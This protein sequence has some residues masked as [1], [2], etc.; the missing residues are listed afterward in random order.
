MSYSPEWISRYMEARFFEFDPVLQG[1]SASF[2]PVDWGELD[3]NS[4]GVKQFLDEAVDFGVGNQG[5]T[6]P[7][8][9]PGGQLA[10]FTI[11][12]QCSRDQWDKLLASFRTD[13]MLLA[14]FTHQRV[15]KLAADRPR[16]LIETL[17]DRFGCQ[18]RQIIG[19]R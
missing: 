3:W 17:A 19:F 15:L 14:H 5:Y 4:G 10:I 18:V 2:D 12:K 7:V 1:A 11:N 8:R 9:G 13:F 6:I 16:K